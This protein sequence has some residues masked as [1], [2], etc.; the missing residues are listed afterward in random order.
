MRMALPPPEKKG[1][2]KTVGNFCKSIFL[3]STYTADV[4]KENVGKQISANYDLQQ[5]LQKNNHL[6]EAEKLKY[7]LE[8][9][10][11]LQHYLQENAHRFQSQMESGRKQFEAEK[12]KYQLDANADL[13]GYLQE[14]AHRFQS[15]MESG[16]KQFEAEKLKYQLDTNADLQ[17]SL[18]TNSFNFQAQLEKNRQKFEL[19]RM[20]VQYFMQLESQAHQTRENHLN[21]KFQEKENQLTRLHQSEENQLNREFQA[22]LT[23]YVKKLDHA[24]MQEKM[25]FDL[26]LFEERKKLDIEMRE[27]THNFQLKLAVLHGQITRKTEEYRRTLDRYPWGLPPSTILETYSKYQDRTKPVPPLIILSPPTLEYDRLGS[28][29]SVV[30][31]PKIEKRLAEN[32]RTFLDKYYPIN[33]GVRPTKFIGGI[34]ETKAR[35]SENAVELLFSMFSSVPTL[36]FES[37]TEGEFLNFRIASWDVGQE[38]YNYKSILSEFN[39][40]E[41]LYEVAKFHAQNWKVKKEQLLQKGR[42]EEELKKLGGDD[43]FNLGILEYEEGLEKD[44]YDGFL[45]YKITPKTIQELVKHLRILH[46]IFIGLSVDEYYFIR[47]N[48]NPQLPSIVN[49]LIED[50][51]DYERIYLVEVVTSY[52]QNLCEALKEQNSPFLP[53]LTLEIACG[54]AKTAEIS[55]IEQMLENSMRAW[56]KLR[57]VQ[58]HKKMDLLATMQSHWN[59]E[60]DKKYVEQLHQYFLAIGEVAIAGQVNDVLEQWQK[61]KLKDIIF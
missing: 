7:Q 34:W 32:V 18:Q 51:P 47:Y 53:E 44:G 10:T 61:S 59:K 41:F 49:E 55:W 5:R 35:H 37:E 25:G 23:A 33:D 48:V 36:I 4:M 21:R 22:E 16:R 27:S 20:K 52:Y 2:W 12:L 13:Q 57:G 28:T 43:E 45:H 31:L 6:F 11:D 1:F 15:Q 56:L 24:M 39:C 42:T 29:S 58:P 60:H 38:T 8:A 3:P 54:L 50:L 17:Y 9:N 46:S 40:T 26:F 30:N 14:N 19:T